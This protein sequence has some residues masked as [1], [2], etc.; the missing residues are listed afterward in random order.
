[1]ARII[2]VGLDGRVTE[3]NEALP[4]L[5]PQPKVPVEPQDFGLPP[6][7]RYADGVKFNPGNQGEGIYAFYAGS[8][9]KLG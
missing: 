5:T 3:T 6:I 4:D 8:W 1:M 9:H 7:I 2:K